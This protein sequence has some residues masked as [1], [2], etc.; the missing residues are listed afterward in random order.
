MDQERKELKSQVTYLE[1]T[2]STLNLTNQELADELSK[3][4]A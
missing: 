3:L 1:S 4:Q 2:I